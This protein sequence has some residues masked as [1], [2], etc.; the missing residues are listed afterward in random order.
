MEIKATHKKTGK[1]IDVCRLHFDKGKL[2]FIMDWNEKIYRA[3][4][5][6]LEIKD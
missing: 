5:V 6:N 2:R 4:E 3:V 1:I